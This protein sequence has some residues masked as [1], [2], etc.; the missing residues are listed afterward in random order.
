MLFNLSV[1]A[2][3]VVAADSTIE[4][5]TTHTFSN[6]MSAIIVVLVLGGVAYILTQT[7][8]MRIVALLVLI[9]IVIVSNAWAMTAGAAVR[10]EIVSFG[11]SRGYDELVTGTVFTAA[12]AF[13]LYL[14]AQRIQKRRKSDDGEDVRI[15]PAW[16]F[17]LFVLALI[18]F[19]F[20]WAQ[21]GIILISDVAVRFLDLLSKF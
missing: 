14:V 9:G 4:G 10:E 6:A 2:G 13:A 12:I 15:H 18:F 8:Q 7:S 3:D 11:M 17:A 19:T 1:L 5:S 16:Y 20:S 21:E